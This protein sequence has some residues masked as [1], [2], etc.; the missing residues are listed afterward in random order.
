MATPGSSRGMLGGGGPVLSTLLRPHSPRQTPLRGHPC[1]RCPEH[2]APIAGAASLDG[3]R[4][5]SQGW[6]RPLPRLLGAVEE[7]EGD[8]V[9]KPRLT[10]LLGAVQ[11][12]PSPSLILK[13]GAIHHGANRLLSWEAEKSHSQREGEKLVQ[14]TGEAK[15]GRCGMERDAVR[16]R[17]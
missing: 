17:R 5:P 6:D 11:A 9:N 12:E 1:L 14:G 7:E 3:R 15:R 13:S 2:H 4:T 8:S 16:A 10:R